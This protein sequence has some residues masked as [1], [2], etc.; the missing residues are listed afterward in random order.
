MIALCF[1]IKNKNE[2]KLMP[3]ISVVI[4]LY[5]AQKYIKNTILSIQNQTFTDFEIIV[6]DDD[7]K[8]DSYKIVSDMDDS[9]IQ[10]YKNEKNQGIAYTRNRAISFCKGE[11]IAF[12]D[13]DDIAPDYRLQHTLDF[14][15]KNKNIVAV[16]GNCRKIDGDGNDLNKQWNVFLNPLL[17]KAYMLF[18]DPIPNG[19]ALIRR[20]FLVENDIKFKDNMYGAEDYRFWAE[21][22][23]KG[24]IANLDEVLLYWRVNHGNET[25]RVCSQCNEKRQ[26]VLADI[27]NF[28]LEAYGFNLKNQELDILNKVFEE[29]G[30]LD[31]NQEI[32][33]F[34]NALNNLIVQAEQMNLSIKKEIKIMCRKRFGEKIAKAFFLWEKDVNT[35]NATV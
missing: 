21:V 23:L 9:R 4:P 16:G 31:S 32:I 17:I 6:V 12:M 3:R 18:E 22:S 14:L 29:E 24:L 30:T 33:A 2:E 5:N 13:D 26:A 27:H 34:Y 1:N 35:N 15:D 11:Y 25:Q 8:D 20:A 28:L 10:L 7:S 19:S